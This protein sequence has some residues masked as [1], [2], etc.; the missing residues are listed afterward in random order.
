MRVL[1]VGMGSIG[2]RHATNLAA[3][4]HSIVACDPSFK[5]QSLNETFDY[6][7][8]KTMEEGLS[9]KPDA[10]FVCSPPALH[11]EHVR[12]ALQTDCHVF[13]EKPI[14]LDIFSAIRLE[15]YRRIADHHGV[16]AVGYMV[17]ALPELIELKNRL[18]GPVMGN[19]HRA[20]IT[21]HWS[22][23]APAS[24]EWPGVLEETSHECDLGLYL[25]GPCRQVE[26]VTLT[27][28]DAVFYAQHDRC[29]TVRYDLKSD[30]PR[31]S[32]GI[33]TVTDR[34]TD[35]LRYTPEQIEPCYK[36]EVEAF[37]KGEPLCT[38]GEGLTVVRFIQQIKE[39]AK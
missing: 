20:D 24:Y 14:A 8:V 22:R 36:A 27:D 11:Y 10:V 30:S 39:A 4:G 29:P 13:C 15:E 26:V 21:C 19:C 3:M 7:H 32:R 5:P 28:H 33:Y 16:F 18:G 23:P 25:F 38:G 2:R 37:L 9:Q 6:R 35:N 34:L 1:V 31:Y 12:A 17:R